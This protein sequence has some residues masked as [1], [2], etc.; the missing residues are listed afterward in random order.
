MRFAKTG[1]VHKFPIYAE[2]T[3]FIERMERNGDKGPVYIYLEDH[4]GTRIP[5]D[6]VIG[7]AQPF[8]ED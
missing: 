1:K 3:R 4:D 8:P 6:A 5:M 7:T 2:F